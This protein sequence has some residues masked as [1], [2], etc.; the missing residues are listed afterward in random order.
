MRTFEKFPEKS[1]CPLCK[2]NEDKECILVAIHGTDEGN[3]CQAT[4]VHTECIERGLVYV[5]DL[6]LVYVYSGV[7]L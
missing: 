1:K 7:K 5:K 2:T 6:D 3:I 4:P